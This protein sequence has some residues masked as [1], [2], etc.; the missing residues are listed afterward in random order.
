MTTADTATR[1]CAED[2]AALQAAVRSLEYPSF[3][4][5]LASAVGEPVERVGRALPPV[6]AEAIAAVTTRALNAAL[7]V[8]L[9]SLRRAPRALSPR[10]HTALAMASGA[11]GGA[12]GL[13][14]L[15]IELPISTVI[16]LRSIADIARRAGEDLT[17][18][19]AAL[20]CVQV[21]ALGARTP[22]STATESGY[23]AVRGIL[24][25]SV[26]EAARYVADRGIFQEGAPV[27]VRLIS[28]L[29]SRFGV[30]VS[31]KLAAQAIPVIGAVGGAAVN[32][33]FIEH[34][35]D[36]A[37]AHF[38]VRRL[39]RIYGKETVRHEY[40]RLRAGI[41]SDG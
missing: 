10:L 22:D 11:A 9:R 23:F 28:L 14:S 38:T 6:A 5:R 16:M 4:A 17:S 29:A 2:R 36:T 41:E 39:E 34:F 31:Q 21:F 25:K 32:Y 18:P 20:A 30:V 7:A 40:E 37:T 1:L 24:A 26:S 12:V 13:V 8:A 15:P 27:L 3:A 19:D 33:A 35:Q